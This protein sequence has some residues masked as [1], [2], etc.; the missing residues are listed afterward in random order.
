MAVV[1]CLLGP[2][3]HC[4]QTLQFDVIYRSSLLSLRRDLSGA[5]SELKELVRKCKVD[6]GDNGPSN[7]V[8]HG[9]FLCFVLRTFVIDC[10][11]FTD[12]CM[13]DTEPFKNSVSIE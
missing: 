3:M 11:N 4:C 7:T 8:E 12:S 9:T 6:D 13:I 10:Y 1:M 5:A 2:H